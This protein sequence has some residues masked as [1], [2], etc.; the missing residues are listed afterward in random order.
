MSDDRTK[1]GGSDRKRV[2]IDEDYEVQF[3]TTR[4]GV[5]RQELEEA[6]R[7]VGNNVDKITEHLRGRTKGVDRD[8]DK[9]R[10]RS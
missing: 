10:D 2:S 3:W 1:R 7:S 8:L 4:L 9:D 6:V 5:S